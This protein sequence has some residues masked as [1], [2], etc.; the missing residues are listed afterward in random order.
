LQIIINQI[1]ICEL[2]LSYKQRRIKK[3]YEINKIKYKEG[4]YLDDF[5]RMANL[6]NIADWEYF[7]KGYFSIQDEST[8]VSGK[9]TRVNPGDRVLDLCAA[10][11]VKLHIL[12]QK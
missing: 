10:P 1:L 8:G 2:I 6:S 4:L 11:V 7:S 9:F 5:I 3:V 12:R